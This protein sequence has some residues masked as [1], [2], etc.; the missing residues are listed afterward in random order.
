MWRQISMQDPNL[1]NRQIRWLLAL[2]RLKRGF[3]PARAESNLSAIAQR[4][5]LLY[6]ETN[7]NWGVAVQPLQELGKEQVR[8]LSYPLA[9]AVAFV[10]LIACANVAGL[11]L[12]R[13]A[14]Q[15]VE[16]AVRVALGAGRRQL[17]GQFFA[18][19]V[20]L[21]LIGGLVGLCFATWSNP[22]LAAIVPAGFDFLRNTSLDWPVFGFT[23]A[24]S[25]TAGAA[26]G[27]I[28]A[29]NASGPDPN[30]DLRQ[31][32]RGGMPPAA[33][34]VR[35]ALGIAEVG[36]AFLL[37]A[38]TG[39][40]IRT[41]VNLSRVPLGFEPK[42]VLTAQLDLSGSRYVKVAP[43]REMD[44]RYV[45]PRVEAFYGEVVDR[46][47]VLPG[48]ESLGLVSWLP[49]GGWGSGRRE[50]GFSIGGA[51][52]AA[53]GEQR[54]ADYNAVGGRYFE[55]LRIRLLKGRYLDARDAAGA[56]WVVVV[57][58]AMARRF[59]PNRNPLG[60]SLL[61]D[62]VAEERPRT[63]VGV[64]DNVRQD[65]PSLDPAPEMYVSFRQQPAVYPGHGVQNRLRMS[66]V[67][68][69]S[70]PAAMAPALRK[71]VAG[72][73]SK[74]PLLNV[75]TMD[76]VLGRS[77]APARFFVR[78]LGVFGLVAV[79]LA[80]IGIYGVISCNVAARTKE[81]GIRLALGAQRG[82][83]LIDVLR[84][85]A[86]LGAAGVIF[87]AAL[88]IPLTRVLT[89]LL[90]GVGTYDLVSFGCVSLFLLVIIAA[91]ALQ[92][93]W[94]ALRTDPIAALRAE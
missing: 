9:G 72:L 38:G 86:A 59:W 36:L 31:G 64:V 25:L 19:S 48:V 33:Q 92:P 17:F 34:R 47:S 27:L 49:M 18:E 6:P 32:G 13:A 65:A 76:E 61:L 11:L 21:A 78:V 26:I 5:A 10:F 89:N 3:S 71:V 16:I 85:A 81:F 94:K 50:R 55:A 66:I 14:G 43:R 30:V 53:P 54:V 88:S 39:L 4:L 77:M 67:L 8:K 7:R 37:L 35:S 73:D 91:A 69:S 29:L 24:M 68:R 70:Y 58:Q 40:L 90:Y 87:G 56:P 63:V 93:A 80:A 52:P 41:L 57:N 46:A 60:Q 23:L 83:V 12:A 44:M 82:A 1:I 45:D 79:V 74:Q 75:Q 22:L 84:K 15:K 28:V 20:L 2:G 42:T 62:T 51:P